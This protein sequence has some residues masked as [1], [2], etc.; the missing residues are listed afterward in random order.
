MLIH[1]DEDLLSEANPQNFNFHL[2]KEMQ[3]TLKE[4]Q[5]ETTSAVIKA[6]TLARPT[7]DFG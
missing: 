6:F 2:E 3:I 4:V 5:R 1:E 7:R